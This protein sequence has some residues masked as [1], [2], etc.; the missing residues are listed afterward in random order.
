MKFNQILIKNHF[1]VILLSFLYP[2]ILISIRSL[3]IITTDL[4]TYD[5][6]NFIYRFLLS[7]LL[8]I[9]LYRFAHNSKVILHYKSVRIHIFVWIIL[10]ILIT[11]F[12]PL[13]WLK[14]IEMPSILLE[15]MFNLKLVFLE[16]QLIILVGFYTSLLCV[17]YFKK[18]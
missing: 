9:I 11:I 4:Y 1:E 15:I 2:I 12:T 17:Y 5:S 13:A 10:F 18:M 16:E 14:I 7:F 8:G 6:I 3:T